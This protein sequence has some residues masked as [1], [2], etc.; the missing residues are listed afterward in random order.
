LRSVG[1]IARAGIGYFAV[2]VLMDTQELTDPFQLPVALHF[3]YYN[4]GRIH[5][6]TARDSCH[7]GRDRRSRVNAGR[8]RGAGARAGTQAAWPV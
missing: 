7:A 1:V 6:T 8:N 4:F 2:H 5:K 3:M